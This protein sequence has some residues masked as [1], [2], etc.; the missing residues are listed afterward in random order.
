MEKRGLKLPTADFVQRKVKELEKF[1][2]MS[3][4]EEDVEKVSVSH[5]FTG[6]GG[7]ILCLFVF[8]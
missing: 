3:L 6:W 2:T 1:K 7:S 8:I 5:P 4:K